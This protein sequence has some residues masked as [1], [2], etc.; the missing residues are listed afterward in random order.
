LYCGYLLGS[1]WVWLKHVLELFRRPVS[2]LNGRFVLREL[3]SRHVVGLDGFDHERVCE[4]RGGQVR[5]QQRI[6]RMHGV[7]LWAVPNCIGRDELFELYG[8]N[9]FGSDGLQR[10]QLR[11]L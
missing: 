11:G 6:L 8:R 2:G 3:L 5:R 9:L 7:L 1:G 4:L 10:E